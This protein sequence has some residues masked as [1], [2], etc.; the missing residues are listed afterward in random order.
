MP[1]EH[2]AGAVR[3]LAVRGR[4]EARLAEAGGLAA[5]GVLDVHVPG[6]LV[7][8]AIGGVRVAGFAV[9]RGPCAEGGMEGGGVGDGRA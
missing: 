2:V 3:G 4:P 9:N 5:R 1:A 6:E 7:G 8:R